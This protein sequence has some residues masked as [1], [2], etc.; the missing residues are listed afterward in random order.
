MSAPGTVCQAVSMKEYRRQDFRIQ[1][2]TNH[3]RTGDQIWS[4]VPVNF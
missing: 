4:D 3:S 1:K 2:I